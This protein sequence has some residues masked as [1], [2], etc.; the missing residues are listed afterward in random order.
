MPDEPLLFERDGA[1]AR[2]VLNRPEAGNA[3]DLGLAQG[4]M[5]A[6]IECDED[7]AIRCVVL[8]ARGR[9]FCAGG[10][11]RS[12]QSAGDK[13][14]ALIAEITAYLHKALSRLM[15]MDKPLVTAIN[16]PAAGAGVS[17]S[18]LGDIVLAARSAHFTVAYTALGMMPD[19]GSTWLLPP[20]IGLR[21]T[22]EQTIAHAAAGVDGQEGIQ[23]FM[24]K[25]TPGFNS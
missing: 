23:A 7:P 16:G 3:L 4:L 20:L 13:V 18:V 9:L 5:R 12:F 15:R 21:R 10:D 14:G 24:T 1:V 11:I 19:A 8:T 17:L 25:Q 2:L 22:Q 6:A